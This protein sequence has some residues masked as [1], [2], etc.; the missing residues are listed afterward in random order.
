M[1]GDGR[2]ISTDKVDNQ[3]VGNQ[4]VRHGGLTFGDVMSADSSNPQALHKNFLSAEVNASQKDDGIP[5]PPYDPLNTRQ[6]AYGAI[7]AIASVGGAIYAVNRF[8]NEGRHILG[9]NLG[10]VERVANSPE[11]H[12]YRALGSS[13]K[14]ELMTSQDVAQRQVL[15]LQKTRPELF[16]AG[17]NRGSFN[18]EVLK[19]PKYAEMSPAE[20]SLIDRAGRLEQ[21]NSSLG[22]DLSSTSTTGFRNGLYKIRGM[23]AHPTVVEEGMSPAFRRLEDLGTR[24]SEHV[25]DR[26]L[27]LAA[28]S[29]R[30]FLKNAGV[31]SAGLLT[32]YAI[33]KT[34]LKDSAPDK[35]TIGIDCVAPAVVLTELP[36]W[37]KFSVI[38][39]AHA[40]SRLAEYGMRKAGRNE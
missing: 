3:N 12:E 33:E 5:R 20:R 37:A 29:N 9:G 36:L 34:I 16:E 7:D 40:V 35:L 15:N 25:T 39:G 24:A 27:E 21:V 38:V 30:L 18:G 10:N 17:G 2:I 6:K 8:Q 22:R 26:T 4:D 23:H 31:V 13:L 11:L 32:N 19:V 28:E 1:M 14:R